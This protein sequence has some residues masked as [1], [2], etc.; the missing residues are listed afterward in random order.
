MEELQISGKRYISS[1]RAAKEHKY[2]SDYIGQLVRA[3]KVSGQKVGRA[4]YVDATSLSIYL[5]KEA[6]QHA[7][8]TQMP[9]ENT[10][11]PVVEVVEEA[12][13]IPEVA[14]VEEPKKVSEKI[15]IRKAEPVAEVSKTI[16][17]EMDQKKVEEE[18]DRSL[19]RVPLHAPRQTAGVKKNSKLTYI[20]DDEQFFP[21][22]QARKAMTSLP[23]M[24]EEEPEIQEKVREYEHVRN[25]QAERPSK[26]YAMRQWGTLAAAGIMTL[27][28][29]V[30]TSYLFT[31][32]ATV[33]GEQMTST[34]SLGALNL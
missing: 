19:H 30:G 29:V 27:V 25:E 12:P 21:R 23:P 5:G 31:Y 18:I 22:V 32:K 8:A 26:K 6:T 10:A 13:Q 15:I 1:R 7:S 24:R 28:V 20:A 3:G 34:V 17:E 14:I 2:H 16:S 4:W 33:D 11:S 9:A